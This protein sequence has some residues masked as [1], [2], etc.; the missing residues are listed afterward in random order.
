MTKY[1]YTERAEKRAKELRLEERK[2]G[3]VAM[4]GGEVL[5]SGQTAEAWKKKGYIV[6][7]NS[8][9][10]NCTRCGNDCNGTT[11]QTWTGCIYKTI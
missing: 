11:C 5:K 10:F 6:E 2:A 3:T 1:I 8:M 9:C 4:F 7:L